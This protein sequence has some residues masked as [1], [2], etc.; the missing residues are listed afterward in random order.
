[1]VGLTLLV[2]CLDE[3]LAPW[4]PLWFAFS[5]VV[6]GAAALE[7]VGLMG[8]TSARPSGNTV[9]GGVLA[10]VVAN[11]VPHLVDRLYPHGGPSG[12]PPH[13]PSAPVSVLAWPLLTFV[14]VV[15]AAFIVQGVQFRKPGATLATIAGTV[16]AVAYIGL[17]AGFIVQF[18]WFDGPYHGL[19]PL[20]YL[21]A[22]SKGADTGA[23]TLGRIAGRHKL[24][25]RLSPNKT[26]EGAFGGLLFGTGAA[27]I[28]EAIVR[29]G[30]HSVALGWGSAA[31]FGLVVGS[32]A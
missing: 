27:L 29:Y 19:V 25:P 9:F 10:L 11:W 15:M 32:A 5:A 2:L 12:H 13:D 31:A 3:W 16:L 22:T 23:Y 26:I 4:Y 28:V 6:M 18:R 21:I 24:W 1:M 7:L 8:E 14:A 30:L 17:L 20:V